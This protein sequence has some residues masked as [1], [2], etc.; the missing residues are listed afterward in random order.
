MIEQFF[1]ASTEL[2]AIYLMQ[3]DKYTD[4]KYSPI[5]GLLAQPFWAYASYTNSQ[6]GSFF[7][8][9]L[10]CWLWI[11]SF[12]QYWIDN[13]YLL[14]PEEY[15]TL[16]MQAVYEIKTSKLDKKDFIDRVLREALR[17]K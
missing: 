5:F 14:T 4:K 15:H 12:K 1:I 16:I 13:K 7:I 2:I 3:S 17:I 10:F 8:G 6:W 11:K 9:F